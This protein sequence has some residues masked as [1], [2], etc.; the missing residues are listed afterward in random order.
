MFLV[1]FQPGNEV[2]YRS[3]VDLAAAIRA[4][5]VGSESRIYHRNSS[6][7]VPITVHPE[8]KRLSGEGEP[9]PLKPL[10][11]KRWTFF[12]GEGPQDPAAGAPPAETSQAETQSEPFPMLVQQE[13]K[14]T[15]RRWVRRAI[16]RLRIP[17]GA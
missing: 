8:Y 5:E 2:L 7:W 6:T 14:Q 10:K 15:I 9:V 1:E 17:G 16:R 11:R 4:G 13:E 12:N 3:V